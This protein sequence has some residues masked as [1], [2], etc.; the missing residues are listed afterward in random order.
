VRVLR[1]LAAGRTEVMSYPTM[2]EGVP[3]SV[4]TERIRAFEYFANFGTPDDVEVFE[5]NHIGLQADDIPW[6]TLSRGMQPEDHPDG[7]RVGNVTDEVPQRA[8]MGAWLRAMSGSGDA[9]STSSGH[10]V[11][12]SR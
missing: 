3:D 8:Q 7:S 10:G 11:G 12:E 5:R 2:L 1:P 9:A 4:N 6:L